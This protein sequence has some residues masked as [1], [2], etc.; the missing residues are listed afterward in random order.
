[1]PLFTIDDAKDAKLQFLKDNFDKIVA[2]TGEPANY[3][4]ANTNNGTGTGQ[5][6]AEA[7]IVTADLTIEDGPT[8]GRQ[9]TVAEKDTI[10]PVADGTATYYA[11][12]D[13]T[14]S[15]ILHYATAPPKALTTSGEVK[16]AEHSYVDRDT[17]AVS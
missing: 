7:A 10:T 17:T 6:L 5:K 3:S 13:T 1:M 15:R 14:N 8:D 16:F 2:L 4:D 12:L 9:L 11:W